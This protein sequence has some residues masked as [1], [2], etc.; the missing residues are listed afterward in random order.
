MEL[1]KRS[2]CNLPFIYCKPKSL[3]VYSIDISPG[4]P[5][6]FNQTLK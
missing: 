2:S 5:F 6:H 3:D 1:E 4:G